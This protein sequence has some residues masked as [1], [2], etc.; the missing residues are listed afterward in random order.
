MRRVLVV[1]SLYSRGPCKSKL[2]GVCE[3]VVE[4]LSVRT[5]SPSPKLNK[6]IRVD[7]LV[8][9]LF[10]IFFAPTGTRKRR[11]VRRPKCRRPQVAFLPR[12]R[13]V[14]T[15]WSLVGFFS[16]IFILYPQFFLFMAISAY[17]ESYGALM[18]IGIAHMVG[19]CRIA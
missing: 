5:S 8:S 9:P 7:I 19:R 10:A 1:Y 12:P 15:I 2:M 13:V 18:C 4:E 6:K 3:G 14:P 16:I 17:W 11:I